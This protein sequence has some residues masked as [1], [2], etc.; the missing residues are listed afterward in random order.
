M[1]LQ[2]IRTS[3]AA[4]EVGDIFRMRLVDSTYLFG[5]VINTEVKFATGFD[6]I[7]VHV[8]QSRNTSGEPPLGEMT[9]DRLLI[10]PYLVNRL[11]WSRG[12]FE[13]VAKGPLPSS[14]RPAGLCFYS[15]A[16][17]TYRDENG[18]EIASRVEPCG[19]W[20]LGN[21]V[22]VD[23]VITGALDLSSQQSEVPDQPHEG[24]ALSVDLAEDPSFFGVGEDSFFDLGDLEDAISHVIEPLSGAVTGHAISWEGAKVTVFVDG[25]DE[26]IHAAV[27]ELIEARRG[28]SAR[29]ELV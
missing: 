13:T 28:P 15:Q 11:P 23:Q 29:Y 27:R 7:L 24:L 10:R 22:T 3:R 1:N 26:R 17:G 18:L 9:I 20:A 8:Y 5:R 19:L 16:F 4:P 12:Y 2:V 6:A 25:H 21:H 14:A